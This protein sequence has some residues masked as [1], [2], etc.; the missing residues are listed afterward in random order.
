M[1]G[2]LGQISISSGDQKTIQ[3]WTEHDEMKRFRKE[4]VQDREPKRS[5]PP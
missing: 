2:K 5:A 4:A 3:L 1:K